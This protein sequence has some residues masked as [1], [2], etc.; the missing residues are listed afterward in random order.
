MRWVAEGK[1]SSMG[2]RLTVMEPWP[3]RRRIR[4]TAAF[5]RPVDWINGFGTA[6]GGSFF[7]SV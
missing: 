4:A 3:G 5:R 6:V 1:Y 7:G 2:R